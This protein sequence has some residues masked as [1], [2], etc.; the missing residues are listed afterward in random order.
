M[1]MNEERGIG[2][3]K[4]MWDAEFR[5]RWERLREREREKGARKRS[6]FPSG[7]FETENMKHG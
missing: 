4:Q 6:Q 3:I 2:K 5:K 7:D 1:I